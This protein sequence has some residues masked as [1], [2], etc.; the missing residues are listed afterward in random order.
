MDELGVGRVTTVVDDD[1]VRTAAERAAGVLSWAGVV[2]PETTLFGCR[3]LPVV[4]L[5]ATVHQMRQRDGDGPQLDGD[6][7]ALWEWPEAPGPAPAVRLTGGL[8]RLRRRFSDVL[9]QARQ[10]RPFGP[11]A[12][13]APASTADREVNRWEVAMYGVGLV[14]V[15]ATTGLCARV[16]S[17]PAEAGRRAPARRR[18]A[19]RWIEETLYAR[20]IEANV[21]SVPAKG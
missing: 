4:L 6:L 1:P 2:L 11:A 21:F 7:L 15:D 20:A 8:F 19:D 14:A 5:D 9:T 16:A 12:V 13:L 17:V 18:T 10:W 3:L